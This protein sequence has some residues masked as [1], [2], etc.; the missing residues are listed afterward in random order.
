MRRFTG[1]GSFDAGGK[2]FYR[3]VPM[4]RAAVMI[5]IF[6]QQNFVLR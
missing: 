2:Q 3:P 6:L 4:R 5:E 1:D